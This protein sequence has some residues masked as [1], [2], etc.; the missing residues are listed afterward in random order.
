[1]TP[2]LTRTQFFVGTP[3]AQ[4]ALDNMAAFE[5]RLPPPKAH[6]LG[7]VV[8]LLSAKKPLPDRAPAAVPP[9]AHVFEA[10]PATGDGARPPPRPAA[11]E[12]APQEL[13]ELVRDW[14]HPTDAEHFAYYVPR[15]VLPSPSLYQSFVSWAHL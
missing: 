4:C 14:S 5:A 7:R 1:V 2:T 6:D 3:A 11:L 15:R 10:A 13:K 8:G 9:P 12:R